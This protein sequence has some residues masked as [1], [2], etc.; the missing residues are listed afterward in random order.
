MDRPVR[1]ERLRFYLAGALAIL[2][3]LFCQ[4]LLAS[5]VEH[6]G[7]ATWIHFNHPVTQPILLGE[8]GTP[9]QRWSTVTLTD[10]FTDTSVF[11]T[12]L[13]AVLTY[14][15]ARVCYHLDVASV[16]NRRARWLLGGWVVGTG[17]MIAIS[18]GLGVV[19]RCLPWL[20]SSYW[21]NGLVGLV[22]LGGAANLFATAWGKMM[23]WRGVTEAGRD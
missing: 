17:V 10:D 14:Y 1:H 16:M 20:V 9:S 22:V 15:F 2:F 11:L 23:R 19:T 7:I 8:A 21:V 13:S 18:Q 4:R 5:V 12:I 3:G 6:L